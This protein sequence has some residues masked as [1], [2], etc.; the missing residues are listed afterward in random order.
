MLEFPVNVSATSSN[1]IT[2]ITVSHLLQVS[3]PYFPDINAPG[4]CFASLFYKVTQRL[5]VT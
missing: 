2:N 1:N 3:D 5:S 4:C